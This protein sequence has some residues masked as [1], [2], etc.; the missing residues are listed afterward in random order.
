MF[1]RTAAPADAPLPWQDRPDHA[2]RDRVGDFVLDAAAVARFD[3][4]LH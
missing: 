1:I 2:N 3:R 4:L